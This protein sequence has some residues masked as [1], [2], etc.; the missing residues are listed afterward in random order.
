MNA[1]RAGRVP[2]VSTL[3]AA[4]ASFRSSFDAVHGGRQRSPKFPS[5]LPIRLLLGQYRRTGEDLL[6]EMAELTLVKMAAGGIYDQVGGG[7]H[8]YATDV[9]WLV[10]H[11]EKMLYDNALLVAAYLEGFQVTGREEFAAVARDVLTYV[12]REMTAPGGAFFSATDADSLG[13]HGEREEGWFFTWTPAELETV[14]GPDDAA[15][16]AAYYA[17]TAGGNFEGR[18]IL[19][20]PRS[21]EDVARRLGVPP[22]ELE[23]GLARSRAKLYQVRTLRPPPLRDDKILTSW[24][25]LMISAMARAGFV[26]DEPEFVDRARKAAEFLLERSRGEGRLFRSYMD[27]RARH[28][29][30][31]DDYS[32]LIAGLLDLFESTGEP[33]W[34]SEALALQEVLERHYRNPK[35]GGYF[36]TSDDHETLLAREMPIYDGAEPS[37]NSVALMNLLR[38]HELTTDDRHRAAAQALLESLADTIRRSPAG[39]SELLLGL[40][41]WLDT[42]KEIV[43]VTSGSALQARPFL[44]VLRH[45][46]LPNKVVAV[47]PDRGRENEALGQLMPLIQGKQARKGQATAYVCERGIC[48]LPTSDVEVFTR[49]IEQRQTGTERLD[50]P[51]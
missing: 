17:V 13:P 33:R 16:V 20:A 4:L 46:H 21:K 30:Y 34:L 10:P 27:G 5:N 11:F 14:L 24:N 49:Q 47:V 44:D 23:E 2:D 8:R 42:P 48:Q 40:D 45:T 35:G 3:D 18:N 1:A 41:F 31:L 37:G 43:I 29:A 36:M 50:A 51:D 22:E 15:W 9:K 32:F 7:F 39:V 19:H 25:G 12:G 38:L 6:R 26:L 28:N